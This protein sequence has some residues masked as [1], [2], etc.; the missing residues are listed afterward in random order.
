MRF[1]KVWVVFFLIKLFYVFFAVFIYSKLTVLGDTFGYLGASLE[2][3]P[4][5]IYSSTA[6]MDFTGALFKLIF[7]L[8]VI[9]CLPCM[10]LAFYGVYYA[11]D[12]LNL[13]AYALPIVFLLSFPNFG[14]W[15]SIHGKEA[16]GC[17]FSGVLAVILVEL[18]Q[19]KYKFKLIDFI[20]FY[21]CAVFKPQYL[22][23]ITQAIILIW[24]SNKFK[25][26]YTTLVSGTVIIALN[27]AVL[28]IFRDFIDVLAKGMIINF[29][30]NNDPNLAKSTRSGVEWLTQY[31][32]FNSAPYGM[33]I[34][35]FGPTPSEML[36]KPTHLL[37]G[38][39]S[40]ALIVVLISL[41]LPQVI[42]NIYTLRFNPTIF[43]SYTLVFLG[44]LFVHYPFGFLN[45]GSAIRYRCN[46][47]FLFV[48]LAV[49]LLNNLRLRKY[50]QNVE[51]AV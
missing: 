23:F 2:L 13:Y 35:F 42:R 38:L 51:F 39:E 18:I 11:V 25:N 40:I 17:F 36:S 49:N 16:V 28:Y 31:G 20:A 26:K 21:L 15:T 10:M 32:F 34:S 30:S 45:P 43:F 6:M 1:K 37:S 50:S 12:R 48:V 19:G 29:Q 24:F 33:F 22:L 7:R 41:A 5:I 44:I 27:I 14:V 47:Y 46:F 8:D 9:A 3:T 4:R